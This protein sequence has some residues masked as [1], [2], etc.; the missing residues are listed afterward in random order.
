MDPINVAPLP[1]T[2]LLEAAT[3][4]AHALYPH[5]WSEEQ[6]AFCAQALERQMAIAG[7]DTLFAEQAGALRGFAFVNWG[8]S[9]RKGAPFAH[10]Q[11]I[12]TLP[13]Q[14]RSGVARQLLQAVRQLAEARGACRIELETDTDNLAARTLYESCG[15]ERLP[16]KEV[17][18]LFFDR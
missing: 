8:F 1:P 2:R 14:R 13:A 9:I 11:L 10:I 7:F 18:M 5:G 4:V 15:F 3:V 17:Y 12:F 6:R 16:N